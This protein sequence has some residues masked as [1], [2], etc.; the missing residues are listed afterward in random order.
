MKYLF[1]LL[2]LIIISLSLVVFRNNV[3]VEK[4]SSFSNK[5]CI[6]TDK[7][8]LSGGGYK[9]SDCSGSETCQSTFEENADCIKNNFIDTRC[10]LI[11]IWYAKKVQ[12]TDSYYTFS[13]DNTHIIQMKRDATLNCQQFGSKDSVLIKYLNDLLNIENNEFKFDTEEALKTYN[14]SEKINNKDTK[15]IIGYAYGKDDEETGNM[16]LDKMKYCVNMNS[17]SSAF[18]K[19]YLKDK[20]KTEVIFNNPTINN[21]KTLNTGRVIVNRFIKKI[22][23]G[24]KII[25]KIGD[26]EISSTTELPDMSKTCNHLFLL[27]NDKPDLWIL[28]TS[29]QKYHRVNFNEKLT[30]D[31]TVCNKI[32]NPNQPSKSID[33][34][35]DVVKTESE[36]KQINYVPVDVD[37]KD[38]FELGFNFSDMTKWFEVD[39]SNKITSENILTV[40]SND[41]YESVPPKSQIISQNGSDVTIYTSDR[42]CTPLA[43]C[44]AWNIVMPPKKKD[45]LNSTGETVKINSTDRQCL[46]INLGDKS[47]ENHFI[48]NYQDVHNKR[49]N[50]FSGELEFEQLTN[51]Q[52]NSR[53]KEYVAN[54]ED[55]NKS[56]IQIIDKNFHTI[57]RECKPLNLNYCNNKYIANADHFKFDYRNYNHNNV[58]SNLDCQPLT[59]CESNQYFNH[60]EFLKTEINDKNIYTKNRSDFCINQPFCG[61]NQYIA[62]V[63][64]L[65]STK[66]FDMFTKPFKCQNLTKCDDDTYETAEPEI[67]LKFSDPLK[68]FFVKN[69]VCSA[70]NSCEAHINI[71]VNLSTPILSIYDNTETRKIKE[72]NNAYFVEQNKNLNFFT[73][74]GIKVEYKLEFN[75]RNGYNNDVPQFRTRP[76][77]ILKKKSKEVVAMIQLDI[78]DNDKIINLELSDTDETKINTFKKFP[79]DNF[80]LYL[81][82]GSCKKMTMKIEN[83]VFKCKRRQYVHQKATNETDNVCKYEHPDIGDCG[84]NEYYDLTL[85]PENEEKSYLYKESG[86]YCIDY[87]DNDCRISDKKIPCDKMKNYKNDSI[88]N[89]YKQLYNDTLSYDTTNECASKCTARKGCGA[90]KLNSLT[91]ICEYYGFETVKIEIGNIDLRKF[92]IK[93]KSDD[94]SET[95]ADITDNITTFKNPV[96]ITYLIIKPSSIGSKVTNLSD[97]AYIKFYYYDNSYKMYTKSPEHSNEVDIDSYIRTDQLLEI[98]DIYYIPN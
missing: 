8:E 3:T 49:D 10:K 50:K 52:N 91:N 75:H 54:W 7:I 27:N 62:N 9:P 73:C 76:K 79:N 34:D 25:Y 45:V 86:A 43:E 77:F 31:K 92:T 17:D 13:K 80:E 96:H 71:E 57:N 35:Q 5:N 38:V 82:T 63:E 42:T 4:Y 29:D 23:D 39:S 12:G 90:F 95:E 24:Y 85:S 59:N 32:S 89:S 88:N 83:F 1:L 78:K 87:N 98:Q 2:L 81:D 93:Y 56:K 18:G 33:I 48:K 65:N 14:K 97:E 46:P 26:I 72:F 30:D 58:H 94:T 55:F 51:C 64:E 20:H 84:N 67:K 15:L 19:E 68:G 11:K 40:C 28:H 69:R 53:T 74:E 70:L 60:E 6:Y 66:I 22:D 44:T 61:S 37:T 21:D 41:Q 47:P 36:L 16:T